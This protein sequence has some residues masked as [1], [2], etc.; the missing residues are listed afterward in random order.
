MSFT[1]LQI[2]FMNYV[3]DPANPLPQGTDSRRMGVYRE[4]FFNNI[5]GFIA[6]AFPV[7]KSL[8]AEASWLALVQD[9]FAHHDC[10]TPIFVNIA[11]E[12]LDF[13][14]QEYVP[15]GQDAPFMLE[16]AHYEWLELAVAIAQDEPT[17]AWLSDA[18]V[19]CRPLSLAA[20]ARVAQYTYEVQRI[21][22]DYR[23]A[24]PAASPLFFCVYRD[25]EDEVA[26]LQLNPL[27]AQVLA[28]MA[29]RGEVVLTEIV[30]WLERLYP[31]MTTE[32]IIQGSSQLLRQLAALGIIRS[33]AE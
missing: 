15:K 17:Q 8:Y 31:Q 21:S 13:L 1:E 26:F 9:F 22:Q 19:T 30:A 6:S 3:R 27:S 28:Y 23:P 14:Q 20:T 5:Q 4:L 11:Q 33:P 16:L 12:F 2:A 24:A 18:E 7:L 29:Q 32:A 25:R 10:R